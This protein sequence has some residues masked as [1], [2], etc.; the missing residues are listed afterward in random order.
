ME[1][2]L[3]AIASVANFGSRQPAASTSQSVPSPRRS[4]TLGDWNWD[5]GWHWEWQWKWGLKASC[6]E[7]R[8]RKS[9]PL[10]GET[11]QKRLSERQDDRRRVSNNGR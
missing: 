10:T 8:K 9:M 6:A 11:P 7:S 1:N 5:W 3:T 2:A 4:R